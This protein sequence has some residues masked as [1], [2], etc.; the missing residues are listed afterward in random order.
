[1]KSDQSLR[2]AEFR[3]TVPFGDWLVK[4]LS[5]SSFQ[6]SLERPPLP[7]AYLFTLVLDTQTCSKLK[8]I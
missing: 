3:A 7:N 1:M 8:V 6:R 2:L 5:T 4:E